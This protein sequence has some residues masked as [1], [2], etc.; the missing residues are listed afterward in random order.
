M[1]EI[2]S[3]STIAVQSDG[4]EEKKSRGRVSTAEKIT[5]YRWRYQDALGIQVKTE[6]EL[7]FSEADARADAASNRFLFPDL[8]VE[9]LT[10]D[11][12]KEEVDFDLRELM[13]MI[14]SKLISRDI[15]YD[16]N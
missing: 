4:P 13:F 10:L 8:L 11:V 12:L 16:Y 2:E 1:G 6:K 7:F 3:G 9:M 14:N 5:M 15:I